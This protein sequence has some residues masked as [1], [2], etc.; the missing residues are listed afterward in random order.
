VN[1]LLQ[2]QLDFDQRRTEETSQETQNGEY[3]GP[4]KPPAPG[5]TPFICDSGMTNHHTR[6]FTRTK[7]AGTLAL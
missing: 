3:L 6:F 7:I 4:K 1:L 2:R 5:R